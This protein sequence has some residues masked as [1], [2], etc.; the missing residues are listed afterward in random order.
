M[1]RDSLVRQ[2]HAAPGEPQHS[3]Q[4]WRQAQTM[5]V[6]ERVELRVRNWLTVEVHVL[7]R[8]PDRAPGG[9]YIR[10]PLARFPVE[11]GSVPSKSVTLAGKP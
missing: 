10:H 7:A 6:L 5:P 8:V 3:A 9:Q 11:I 4:V 1:Q 2:L